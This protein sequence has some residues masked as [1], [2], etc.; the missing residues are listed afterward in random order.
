MLR[1]VFTG[2]ILA[3]LTATVQAGE[4]LQPWTAAT[5]GPPKDYS[6]NIEYAVGVS[7]KIEWVADFTNATIVLTQ[8]NHPGDAQGGPS[9]TLE[10]KS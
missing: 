7:I 2:H 3:I 10:R 8:D 6:K 4:F 1:L 9:V 5:A